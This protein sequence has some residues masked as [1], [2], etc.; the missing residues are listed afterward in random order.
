M[1]QSVPAALSAPVLSASP[2]G[3]IPQQVCQMATPSFGGGAG[4]QDSHRL[5]LMAS[6]IELRVGDDDQGLEE[7]GNLVEGNV[8]KRD[9]R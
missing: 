2:R 4:V 6:S 8:K 1:H 5:T 7:T 3:R 9:G